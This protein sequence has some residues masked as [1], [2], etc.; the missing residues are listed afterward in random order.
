MINESFHLYTIVEPYSSR[1]LIKIN[2]RAF[3]FEHNFFIYQQEKI[4]YK[5]T[6]KA[7]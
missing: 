1:Y 6:G 4:K 2:I 7:F 5:I 3:L